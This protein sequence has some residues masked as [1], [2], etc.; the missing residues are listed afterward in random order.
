MRGEVGDIETKRDKD[1]NRPHRE[2]A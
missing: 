1:V 2:A